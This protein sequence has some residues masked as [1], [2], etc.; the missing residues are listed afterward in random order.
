MTWRISSKLVQNGLT[1]SFTLPVTGRLLA[2]SASAS[3]TY[4]TCVFSAP[5]YVQQA[6]LPGYGTN[7]GHHNPFTGNDYNYVILAAYLTTD[8]AVTGGDTDNRA[9]ATINLEDFDGGADV[10]ILF[11][12]TFSTGVDTVAHVAKSLGSP[13]TSVRN[14]AQGCL[15]KSGETLTFKWAQ[16]ATTGLALPASIITLDIV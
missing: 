9:V 3:A 4:E 14:T 6:G 11:T 8:T 10:G 12:L 5:A 2:Q 1:G 13:S 7:I 16:S 15:I